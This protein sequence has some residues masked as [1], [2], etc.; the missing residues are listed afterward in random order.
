MAGGTASLALF[1]TWTHFNPILGENS[2][3]KLVGL[4]SLGRDT[5][6]GA[7]PKLLRKI[8]L[9]CTASE[10]PRPGVTFLC[11]QERKNRFRAKVQFS[12]A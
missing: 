12:C 8:G 5:A 9:H 4:Y 6:F 11:N 2:I 10:F 7:N 1:I 3:S